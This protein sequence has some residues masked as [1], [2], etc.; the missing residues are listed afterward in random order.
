M[1]NAMS[2]GATHTKDG[3]ASKSQAVYRV[4]PSHARQHPKAPPPSLLLPLHAVTPAHK[5]RK[6][7]IVAQIVSYHA[8]SRLL[9]LTS[10]SPTHRNPKPTLLVDVSPAVLGA[11]PSLK[12]VSYALEGAYS[13]L[14]KAEISGRTAGY[15]EGRTRQVV[16]RELVSL[17]DGEWVEV[18]G[19]LEAD[20]RRVLDEIRTSL[21]PSYSQPIPLVLQAFRIASSRSDPSYTTRMRGEV[22]GWNG[23]MSPLEGD[24]A[25]DEPI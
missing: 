12:D 25:V 23:T 17:I 24:M 6:M 5:D 10:H 9:L 22:P 2:S 1:T 20:E 14:G 8:P 11:S 3:S 21:P 19:R 4:I 16:N 7:R 18:M 13:E 15:G